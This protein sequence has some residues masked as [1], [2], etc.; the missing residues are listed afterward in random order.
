VLLLRDHFSA[1][2][3]GQQ[4]APFSGLAAVAAATTRLR[5][6]ARRERFGLSYLVASTREQP[7]QFTAVKA[8]ARRKSWLPCLVQSRP[9]PSGGRRHGVAFRSD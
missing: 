1:G 4:L 6:L 3:F 5:L 7:A 8:P 2:P 9:T